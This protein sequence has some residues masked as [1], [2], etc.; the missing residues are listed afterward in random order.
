MTL[1]RK[2][3]GVEVA[4]SAAEEAAIRAEW[5]YN[6]APEREQEQK[7]RR[8]QRLITNLKNLPIEAQLPILWKWQQE[9]ANNPSLTRGQFL[10]L[11]SDD[12]DRLK[13]VFG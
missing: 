4:L 6:K 12:I 3:N 9:K 11:L 5:E 1:T 8:K 2:V 13:Q 7:S 10:Q